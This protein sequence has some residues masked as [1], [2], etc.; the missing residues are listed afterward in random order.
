[1]DYEEMVNILYPDS[2]PVLEHPPLATNLRV[3]DTPDKG[4]QVQSLVGYREGETLCQ[5]TGLV[6]KHVSQHTLTLPGGQHILDKYFVG[7]LA[8]SC[9]PN[10]YV[11][12]TNLVVVALKDITAGEYLSMDYVHEPTLFHDFKCCC[13]SPNCRHF[14]TGYLTKNTI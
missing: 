14:I 12:M 4:K 1:M 9:S 8:H 2:F 11:D 10:V 6:M 5:F 3:V 7:Y 13:G